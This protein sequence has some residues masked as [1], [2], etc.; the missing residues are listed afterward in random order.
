MMAWIPD[1][2]RVYLVVGG[3]L[4]ILLLV[5]SLISKYEQYQSSRRLA[6]QRIL[7]VTRV[8]ET[9]LDNTRNIG[10]PPGLG[11]LLRNELLARYFTVRQIYP[12]YPAINLLVAQA[13]ERARNEIEGQA[14][15]N[16]SAVTSDEILNRYVAGSND[17]L[18]LL[19][20]NLLGQGL[21]RESRAAHQARLLEFQL[22]AAHHLFTR[23]ALDLA[24]KGEW[25]KAQRSIRSLE[26]FLHGR[27]GNTPQTTRLRSQSRMMMQAFSEQRMPDQQVLGQA[28]S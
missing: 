11:K 3:L 28:T 22:L 10:L 24:A 19:H 8:I 21:S 26:S 23:S 16:S 4:L 14:A 5:A 1:H 6:V 12:R 7:S 18:R 27:S 17:I 13:E 9:S 2:L 20:G 25:Y 15:P